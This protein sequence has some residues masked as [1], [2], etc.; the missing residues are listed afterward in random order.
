MSGE[1]T[2]FETRPYNF[3]RLQSLRSI[4]KRFLSVE[5]R[6]R[7]LR[8]LE[9]RRRILPELYYNLIAF[10]LNTRLYTFDLTEYQRLFTI[11][12]EAGD[13]TESEQG[14][15][16]MRKLINL[17]FDLTQSC[18]KRENGNSRCKLSRKKNIIKSEETS[19]QLMKVQPL[20]SLSELC[21]NEPTDAFLLKDPTDELEELRQDNGSMKQLNYLNE[22]EITLLNLKE[23]ETLEI[24]NEKINEFLFDKTDDSSKTTEQFIESIR[25]HKF[26]GSGRRYFSRWTRRYY[27]V[28]YGASGLYIIPEKSINYS[29]KSIAVTSF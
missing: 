28:R 17:L 24:Q 7:L 4:R 8:D 21:D 18:R 13:C 20:P 22:E 25:N 5:L 10:L 27:D 26:V 16:A 14:I 19:V 11:L 6:V 23:F 2:F 9:Q 15:M 1:Q 29:S 12:I 3:E